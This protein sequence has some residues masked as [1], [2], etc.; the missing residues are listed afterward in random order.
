MLMN[1]QATA[2]VPHYPVK[3]AGLKVTRVIDLTI[4]CDTGN[5]PTHKPFLPLSLGHMIQFRAESSGGTKIA[6][7]IRW[8]YFMVVVMMCWSSSCHST[9]GTEPKVR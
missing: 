4:G 5:P 1:R 2:G 8:V 9:S 3:I 7:T 6:L